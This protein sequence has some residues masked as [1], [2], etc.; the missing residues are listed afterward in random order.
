MSELKIGFIGGGALT[1]SLVAG[2]VGKVLPTANIFVSDHKSSRCDYLCNQ[3]GVNATVGAESFRAAVDVLFLSVKPKD[4]AKAM[5]ENAAVGK[6]VLIVS[7][8]AGVTLNKIE[9]AF[10]ANPCV[11]VMPNTPQSVGAGLAAYALGTK[12]EEAHRAFIEKIFGAVGKTAAITENLMDAATGLSGS[13]P[14]FV[15]LAIDA[16]TDGGV[17]AGLP[18]K[19]AQLMAAQTVMGAAKMV[20]DTGKHPDELRDMVTSPAGTTIAGVRAL[21]KNAFRSSLIEAVLSA[22]KRSEELGK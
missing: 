7:V 18:R 16:L 2:I 10:P 5:A 20:L 3:Y 15:F 1:E 4:A 12:A 22:T 6:N 11:R 9:A 14:A 21:E 8:M 17:A 13:G 19:T